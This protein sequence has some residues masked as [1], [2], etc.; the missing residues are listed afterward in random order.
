MDFGHYVNSSHLL[1]IIFREGTFEIFRLIAFYDVDVDGN[2]QL[3][4]IFQHIFFTRY[5]EPK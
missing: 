3:S 5:D 4:F 2:L 1:S